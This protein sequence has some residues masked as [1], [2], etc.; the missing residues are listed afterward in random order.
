MGAKTAILAFVD[1]NAIQPLRQGNRL[2]VEAARQI[3]RLVHPDFPVEQVSDAM[4]G[5]EIW[6]D[7]DHTYVAAFAGAELLCDRRFAIHRPSQL[8]SHLLKM[9]AG[10]RVLLHAMNTVSDT[11]AI[12]MWE[13]GRLRRALS[14]SP[15]GVVED[16]G[17]PL[18]FEAPYW[19]TGVRHDT[20][21]V[22]FRPHPAPLQHRTRRQPRRERSR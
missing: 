5:D 8:S 18:E 22:P 17:S 9:A 12:G 1:D 15:G 14:V 11:L 4:L 19:G 16:I 10:R 2:T 6:P 7:D 3:V 20:A 13:S 21:S